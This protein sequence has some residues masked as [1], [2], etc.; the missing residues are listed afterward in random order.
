MENLAYLH[1]VAAWESSNAIDPNPMAKS[2]NSVVSRLANKSRIKSGAV[3]L[4]IALILGIF[5]V[6]CSSL[7]ALKLGDTGE[8]VAEIQNQLIRQGFYKG[9]ISGY[10][11]KKTQKAVKQFQSEQNITVDG[12]VGP[13]TFKHLKRSQVGFFEF[14]LGY[15]G[16]RVTVLQYDLNRLGYYNGQMTGYFG[17]W[18]QHA[19]RQFQKE[20]GLKVTGKAD[21]KT[22]IALEKAIVKQPIPLNQDALMVDK[23]TD[24]EEIAATESE[25]AQPTAIAPTMGNLSRGDKGQQVL[26]LQYQLNSLGYFDGPFTGYFGPLT[27]NAVKR[28]QRDR[29]L[30]IDGIAGRYTQG[31]LLATQP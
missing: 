27:E 6:S 3:L 8:K 13:V 24:E 23:P 17:V 26:E 31:V 12:I 29:G 30:R 21:V 18:T 15:S 4:S 28:L 20:S 9:E 5:H 11:D 16:S 1:L 7:A 10:F 14:G 22:Q 2:R 19:L 25:E